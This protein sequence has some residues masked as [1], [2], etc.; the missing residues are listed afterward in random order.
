MAKRILLDT[1]ALIWYQGDSPQLSQN[2]IKEISTESNT[3][4]FSQVNL[5]EITIKQ[6]IN[7]LPLFKATIEDVYNSAIKDGFSFLPIQNS[8]LY[9]YEKIPLFESHRDPFDRLLI[10]IAY[11][12]DLTII[13]SD[14]N[15]NLYN[16]LIA[17]FW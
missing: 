7:K 15:F 2:V 13:T 12:E 4:F 9:S 14:K 8:H 10:A 6:K 1:H 17:T 11:A 16:N 3:I 5:F